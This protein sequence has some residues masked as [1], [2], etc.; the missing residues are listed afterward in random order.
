[1]GQNG[2]VLEVV[3]DAGGG[4]GIDAQVCRQV[5]V[6]GVQNEGR[7]D[8]I[9]SQLEIKVVAKL[10]FKATAHCPGKGDVG[11]RADVSGVC[12]A[13]QDVQDSAFL[14]EPYQKSKLIK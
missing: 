3:G 4:A 2:R 12:T 6:G 14:A 13:K 8:A 11:S 10:V 5:L 9:A 1:M 7:E